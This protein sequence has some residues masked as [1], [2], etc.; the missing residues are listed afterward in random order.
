LRTRRVAPAFAV[1]V[2][3]ACAAPSATAQVPTAVLEH[4]WSEVGTPHVRV[5]TDAGIARAAHVAE[6]LERLHEQVAR[7]VPALA[8]ES[9]RPRTVFV[10]AS[11]ATYR[12]YLPTF[13]GRA[14]DAAGVFQP[15]PRG[16]WLLL[17]DAPDE[18]L[19]RV[20]LHEYTH[21]LVRSVTPNAPLWLNEGLAQYFST[22]RVD[23]ADARVGEPDPELLGWLGGHELMP[24]ETLVAMRYESADYHAGEGRETFYAESWLLAHMLLNE[25]PGDL[26]RWAQYLEALRRG[27][28]PRAAFRASFGEER[29][30]Q[31][32]L[33][34][35]A[36][37]PGLRGLD[38]SFAQPFSA[39]TLS[40]RESVPVAEVLDALGEMLLWQPAAGP[41]AADAHLD[42]VRALEPEGA[43][44][45]SLEA[46]ITERR[47]WASSAPPPRA[48]AERVAVTRGSLTRAASATLEGAPPT[49]GELR[50]ATAQVHTDPP[51]ARRALRALLARPLA[52]GTRSSV[53]RML[54][55]LAP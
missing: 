15:G 51:A 7:T 8:R 14:E 18:A 25:N 10:F 54:R 48:R 34:L 32:R 6:Q 29:R 20:A 11:E 21:A 17:A 24:I 16:D 53:E 33:E 9:A 1:A 3:V 4:A 42:A 38:W 35:Y 31:W 50:R 23:A 52:P 36:H 13:G 12:H 28:E 19:D 49:A 26:P 27:D 30:L 47:G 55:L 43:A 46:A 22:L 2:A 45:R 40:R 5:L 37:R 44:A 39:L 41:D